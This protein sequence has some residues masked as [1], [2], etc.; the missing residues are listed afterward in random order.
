MAYFLYVRKCT[1]ARKSLPGDSGPLSKFVKFPLSPIL[2]C[3]YNLLHTIP[4]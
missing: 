2:N 1:Q 3:V 4:L